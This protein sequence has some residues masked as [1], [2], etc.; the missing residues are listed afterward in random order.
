MSEVFGECKKIELVSVL[1]CQG[2][3]FLLVDD[4]MCLNHLV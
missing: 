1:E 2:C 3:D 4:K